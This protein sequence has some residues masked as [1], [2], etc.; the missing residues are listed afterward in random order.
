MALEHAAARRL[1]QHAGR[2]GAASRSSTSRWRRP[3][4]RPGR[5]SS[6]AADPVQSVARVEVR[7]IPGPAQP[8]CRCA[9]TWPTLAPSVLQP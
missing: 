7:A 2:L 1:L 6:S 9:S 4:W 3:G 5:S 8:I